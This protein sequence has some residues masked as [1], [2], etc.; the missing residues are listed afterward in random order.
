MPARGAGEHQVLVTREV[1][2]WPRRARAVATSRTI[3][4]ERGLPDF[5][6]LS[7]PIVKLRTTRIVSAAKSTSSQRSAS[8]SPMRR[9]V[10]AGYFLNKR[11]RCALVNHRLAAHGIAAKSSARRFHV[12]PTV[13]KAESEYLVLHPP[14]NAVV[15]APEGGSRRQRLSRATTSHVSHQMRSSQLDRARTARKPND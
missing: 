3:G 11:S 13:A 5:G 9:P 15:F 14:Y 4:T 1:L 12:S 2:S 6:L 8:S 10:N 7:P